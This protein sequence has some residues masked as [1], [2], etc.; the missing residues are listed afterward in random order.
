MA[1]EKALCWWLDSSFFLSSSRPN[2]FSK[3]NRKWTEQKAVERTL[4]KKQCRVVRKVGL[5]A[6]DQAYG[7]F[8]L[9]SRRKYHF[10]ASSPPA[11]PSG[12]PATVLLSVTQLPR[13]KQKWS[14]L[15]LRLSD[16]SFSIPLAPVGVNIYRK[17]A[18]TQKAQT[19]RRYHHHGCQKVDPEKSLASNQILYEQTEDGKLGRSFLSAWISVNKV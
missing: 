3:A 14:S 5:Q 10:L 15:S 12:P 11:P 13:G 19:P 18:G 1:A 4:R 6:N 17:S 2:P 16:T 8:S 7:A 9:R